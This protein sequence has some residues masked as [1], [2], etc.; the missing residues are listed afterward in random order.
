MF[1]YWKTW[2]IRLLMGTCQFMVHGSLAQHLTD[3]FIIGHPV[4]I[5]RVKHA[6]QFNV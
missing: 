6:V 4:M 3:K 2:Y 5:D 1:S